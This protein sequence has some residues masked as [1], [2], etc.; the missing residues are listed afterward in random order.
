M[1][2]EIELLLNA[3]KRLGARLPRLRVLERAG[4]PD[5]AASDRLVQPPLEPAP[6]LVARVHQ[7]PARLGQFVDLRLDLRL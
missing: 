5:Q 2:R 7:A 6:L 3:P 1:E 4:E